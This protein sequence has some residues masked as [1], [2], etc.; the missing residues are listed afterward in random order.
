MLEIRPYKIFVSSNYLYITNYGYTYGDY[1]IERIDL[2]SL[3]LARG[4]FNISDKGNQL[5]INN[6][7]TVQI[8]VIDEKTPLYVAAREYPKFNLYFCN[9]NE[10]LKTFSSPS[11]YKKQLP[12][13]ERI[14]V[15]GDRK[16]WGLNAF[17]SVD[18]S[19]SQ[20]LIFVLT[21]NGWGELAKTEKLDRY[22]LIFDRD[23][24]TLCEHKI[25][26]YEGGENDL[27]FDEKNNILYYF[28]P[29]GIKKYNVK[30]Q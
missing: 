16:I 19:K 11:L 6:K 1:C 21:T 2:D 20:N 12:K 30:Y 15:R 8:L 4:L 18:Y 24:N 29:A 14:V 25:I 10:V 17:V 28:S 5:E 3:K 9:E 22:I 13:P 23:G 7:N 26:P 27:C